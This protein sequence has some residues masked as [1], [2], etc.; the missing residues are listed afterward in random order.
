[1]DELS[2]PNIDDFKI[3]VQRKAG[4]GHREVAVEIDWSGITAA[5]LRILAK[6]AITHNLMAEVKKSTGP[7]PTLVKIKAFD[8]VHREPPC[9][10]QFQPRK[11]PTATEEVDV[12]LQK[13]LAQ[14]TPEERRK[15]LA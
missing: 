11:K 7:F 1:M 8:E 13:L 6:V 14:L 15:L 5:E 12:A 2:R 3:L 4:E 10:V 9:L